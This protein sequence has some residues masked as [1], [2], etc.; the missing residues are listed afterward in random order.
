MNT[1]VIITVSAFF[2]GIIGLFFLFAPDETI[3]LL[4]IKID[5]SYVIQL[6]GSSFIALGIIDW[7]A[8]SIVLGGIYG[9]AIIVGNLSNYLTGS[10]VLIDNASEVISLIVLS[11]Y[12]IFTLLFGILL[13]SDP[14]K[15]S[16]EAK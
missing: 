7:M 5:Q 16:S 11:V 13:F 8:K 1:K 10:F 15:K 2:L 3:N 6:M 4:N 14:L 9:R 12:I